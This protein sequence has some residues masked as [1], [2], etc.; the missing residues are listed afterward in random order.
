M[1]ARRSETGV[2]PLGDRPSGGPAHDS[3]SGKIVVS[4]YGYRSESISARSHGAYSFDPRVK[5][6]RMEVKNQ[7]NPRDG[8]FLFE[9]RVTP[10]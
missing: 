9:F 6:Y 10:Q 4:V 2:I 1:I 7:Q 5:G 3:A 8:W